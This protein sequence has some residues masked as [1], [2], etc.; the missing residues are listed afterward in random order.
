MRI[1]IQNGLSR[2]GQQSLWTLTRFNEAHPMYGG[3][4]QAYESGSSAPVSIPT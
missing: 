3:N 2:H 1:T 4:E